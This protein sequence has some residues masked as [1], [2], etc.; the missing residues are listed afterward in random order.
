MA[1][2]KTSSAWDEKDW[3]EGA[4][5]PKQNA[6]ISSYILKKIKI[7][8]RGEQGLEF[9]VVCTLIRDTSYHLYLYCPG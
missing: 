8:R 1:S 2:S 5:S 7:R 6:K 4:L 3:Q 9:Y